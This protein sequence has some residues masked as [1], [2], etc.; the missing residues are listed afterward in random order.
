MRKQIGNFAAVTGSLA[1]AAAV[2]L[3][4]VGNAYA[5]GPELAEKHEC[6]G[7]HKLDKKGFGPSYKEIAD[8]YKGDAQAQAK[9]AASVKNG[10]TGIWGTKK[11]KPQADVPEGDVKQI[12]TWVLSL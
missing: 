10:S 7:C 12:V 4:P 3:L 2:I 11:M 9:L 6:M 1:V 5:G 8:K